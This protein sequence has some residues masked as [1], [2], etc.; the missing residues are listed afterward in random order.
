MASAAA[1]V[2]I[3]RPL[4]GTSSIICSLVTA[5]PVPVSA[6]AVVAAGPA[7]VVL[8]AAVVAEALAVAA[9]VVPVAVPAPAVAPVSLAAVAPEAVLK[10][11]LHLHGQA[12]MI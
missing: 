8:A 7:A 1:A 11:P 10:R 5:V 3:S 9:L 4:F 2:H 12:R 6:A